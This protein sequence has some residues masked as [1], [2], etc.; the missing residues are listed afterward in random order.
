MTKQHRQG[1]SARRIDASAF[2]DDAAEI[3]ADR[4]SLGSNAVVEG[5]VRIR[6]ANV[7][8]GSG[9][10]IGQGAIIDLPGGSFVMGDQCRL[11]DRSKILCRSFLAGDYVTIHSDL[12]C[13]GSG[14]LSIGS[15]VWVGQNS[16]LNASA[17]LTI[18]NGVGIGTY[19]TVWTHGSH[20]EALEGC[21]INKI[22]P[23]TI[24]DDAWILGAFNV[25]SPGVRIGKRAL[26]MTGSVVT[27]DVPANS[28]Y[29]GNPARD[30]SDRSKRTPQ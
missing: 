25:I 14:A 16:V 30:I 26:V 19:S 24:E 11:G 3:T 4:V 28:T 7:E 15:C 1:N 20:G 18:G 9:T 22:A 2:V 12:L 23:V 5:G 8:I 10:R 13:N 21:V 29:A 17:D 6:A 27:R